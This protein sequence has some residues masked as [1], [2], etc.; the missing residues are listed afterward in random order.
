LQAPQ[1]PAALQTSPA[2]QVVPAVTK[3]QVPLE[4][5]VLLARQDL[6]VIPQ[7]LLQHTPST[8]VFPVGH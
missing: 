1:L 8:Q 6:Q 4:P 7:A 2:P 5:P 3:A